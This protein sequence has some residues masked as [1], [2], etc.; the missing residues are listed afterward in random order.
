LSR[1]RRNRHNDISYGLRSF[2]AP[3]ESTVPRIAPLT[4]HLILCFI[5]EKVLGLPK[6]Y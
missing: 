6:S 5:A 2:T 1:S 4:P 3:R